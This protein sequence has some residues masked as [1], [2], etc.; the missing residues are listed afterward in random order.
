M[1]TQSA[2]S[3]QHNVVP[4]RKL[5]G[6][7]P[8]FQVA[9]PF[10]QSLAAMGLTS[11]DAVFAFDAGRTL[12]KANIGRFRQRRQFE[13]TPAGA[14]R[15]VKV[16]LKRYDRPPILGQLRHW[17]LHHRRSSFA[18]MERGAAEEAAAAGIATP[19]VVACGAQWGL[20]F[21]RRSFLM[22]E[23]IQDSCSLE[24]KLP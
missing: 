8:A 10:R 18:G 2:T 17:L 4:E 6:A 19:R 21:E 9:E 12:A 15:P 7:S 22:T 16:F 5:T 24:S 1:R 23:E 14:G 13:V 20:L 3:S 11:L